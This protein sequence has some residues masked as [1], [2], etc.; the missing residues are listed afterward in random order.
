MGYVTDKNLE[1]LL[2]LAGID[3]GKLGMF[4]PPVPLD[5]AQKEPVDVGPDGEPG[6]EPEGW[7]HVGICVG[8]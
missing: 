3:L 6:E 7:A 5:R 8:L 1:I 4:M 2:K